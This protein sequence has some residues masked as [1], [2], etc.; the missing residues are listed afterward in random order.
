MNDGQKHYL[1]ILEDLYTSF[2]LG[3]ATK[4]EQLRDHYV[5]AINREKLKL[6][7]YYIERNKIDSYFSY[8]VEE[9]NEDSLHVYFRNNVI[10][11]RFVKDWSDNNKIVAI[12]PALLNIN[13]YMLWIAI[14]GEQRKNFIRMSNTHFSS[15]AAATLSNLFE[16]HIRIP[17]T[18]NP[19]Q[20][21]LHDVKELVI[22]AL[23]SKR[24]LYEIYQFIEFLSEN[25]YAK[26]SYLL[27][28]EN[29]MYRGRYFERR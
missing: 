12:S 3:G 13:V 2:L 23:K 10:L 28:Q 5:I 6:I 9:L 25:D 26:L 29:L 14:F 4:S 7:D 8:K 15:E 27:N 17:L 21:A 1:P 18:S 24:P 20:F 22:L 11:Q 19:I 16:E